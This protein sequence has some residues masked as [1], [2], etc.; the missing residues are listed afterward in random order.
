MTNEKSPKIPKKYTCEK[1]DYI[2]SNKK[3]YVKHLSTQKHKILIDTNEKSPKSPKMPLPY[4]CECG[5]E[6]KHSSSLCS[7]K[8]KCIFLKEIISKDEL[9]TSKDELI[10]SKDE[11][12]NTLIKENKEFRKTITEMIPK[13][14][15]NYNNCNNTNY[16]NFNLNV[17][18]NED[19]KDALNMVDFIKSLQIQMEDLDKTG[20]LGFVESASQLL[21]KELS[22]LDVNKRP[23]H[24][25]DLKRETLYIKENDVWEK[26]TEN[27]ERMQQAVKELQHSSFCA[28]P[29]WVKEH[30]GCASHKSEH[31]DLYMEIVGNTAG[32]DK[33]KDVNKIVKKVAK[34][35]VIDKKKT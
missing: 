20:K 24:C 5:K 16:N 19:C 21:I 11:I 13:I 18:L 8:R 3:D 14:G 15:N 7:H 30:P 17:F 33:V 32:V 28:V 35:V 34:E 23:I 26:E 25:S 4:I 22:Q 31:N 9:I 6:Y 12:I 10:T 2:T 27:K 29:T 1:C